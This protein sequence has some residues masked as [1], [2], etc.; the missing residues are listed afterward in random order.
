MKNLLYY[1]HMNC[2]TFTD[3]PTVTSI[4]PNFPAVESVPYTV[5][6]FDVPNG[7]T[8]VVITCSAIGWPPPTLVWLS[9]SQQVT[10]TKFSHSVGVDGS[11]YSSVELEFF[12]GI[13]AGDSGE[14][15]CLVSGSTTNET[16]SV[17]VTLRVQA[18][19]QV[20]RDPPSVLELCPII[21]SLTVFFGLQVRDT[22]CL[23]W[24][25]DTKE[26][27]A[28]EIVDIFIG[29]IFSQCQECVIS[30]D[31]I[32]LTHGPVCSNT[33][34]AAI[35]RGK[36]ATDGLSRTANLLCGL[37]QWHQ[38]H[39]FIRINNELKLVDGECTLQL[40]LP[41]SPICSIQGSV[42]L[43]FYVIATPSAA[44]VVLLISISVCVILV[45][46]YFIRKR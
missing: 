29:G 46:I 8:G 37:I 41:T 42:A 23:F 22:D 39:P 11:G 17:V 15:T 1:K 30:G 35:F 28:E 3:T 43:P 2:V 40:E 21:V 34:S 25:Q 32:I 45:S 14:Y 9:S 12:R 31:S 4:F 5:N 10:Q 44:A 27:I 24:R 18:E 20:S 16:Q 13:S 19:V 7:Y 36:I 26:N 38:H 33:S 6:V